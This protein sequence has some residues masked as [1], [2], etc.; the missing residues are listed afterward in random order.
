M[1]DKKGYAQYS[2]NIETYIADKLISN[3]KILRNQNFMGTLCHTGELF[4][5]IDVNGNV[6]RC[7]NMQPFF[8]MG[9]ITKG[10]FKRFMNTKPCL[11]H[12]CTCTVPAN[13]HM[14]RY[15]NKTNNFFVLKETFSGL[16]HNIKIKLF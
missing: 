2:N 9:N 5:K 10:N 1:K 14:I 16:V 3:T 7:Y 6:T 8:L 12:R 4:F 11:S 13:R 15:G